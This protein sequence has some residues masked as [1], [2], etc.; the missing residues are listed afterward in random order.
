MMGRNKPMAALRILSPLALI[1]TL[2]FVGGARRADAAIDGPLGTVMAGFAAKASPEQVKQ[3]AD[4]ITASPSLQM[5]LEGLAASGVLKGVDLVTQED[6]RLDENKGA[7]AVGGHI[8]LTAKFL[9]GQPPHRR[10]GATGKTDLDPPNALIFS[11]GHLS[12]HIEAPFDRKTMPKEDG[13]RL[14][15]VVREEAK[16]Y[17]QGWNDLIDAQAKGL[18]RPITAAQAASLL[19][20]FKYRSYFIKANGKLAVV[21]TDGHLEA[22]GRNLNAMTSALFE[23]EVP[24]FQ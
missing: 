17:I 14:N 8:L 5:R 4:A 6:E 11:L 24:D 12:Y 22:N 21:S 9:L 7:Q 23:S 3:V 16:A 18:G 1:A 10:V 13:A 2:A 20:N 15:F 19:P